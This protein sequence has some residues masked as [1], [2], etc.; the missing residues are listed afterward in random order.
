MKQ[1]ESKILELVLKYNVEIEL[2]YKK[3][4]V[5][6]IFDNGNEIKVIKCG[7][8]KNLIG[9]I[10]KE[11]KSLYAEQQH[12]RKVNMKELYRLAK[13]KEI[14]PDDLFDDLKK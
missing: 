4:T 5:V 9:D 14:F 8:I 12:K 13:D 7:W 1:M 2:K 10:E 11:C 3:D 6:A